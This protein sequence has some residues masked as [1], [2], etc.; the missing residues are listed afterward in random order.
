MKINADA[1]GLDGARLEHITEHLTARYIE[2]QKIAG[3]QVAV[4]RHGELGY[5][6]SFGSMDLERAKPVQDDTIWRIYSMTKPVTSVALMTLYERGLFQLDDPVG[7]FLPELAD[8]QVAEVEGGAIARTRPPARPIQVRD[9][10]MHTAGLSY[11]GLLGLEAA[12]AVDKL[13]ADAGIAATSLNGPGKGSLAELIEALGTVPLKFDPGTRWHYSYATDVCSRLVEVLSGQRFSDYL[14]TTMFEPLG[15][16]DTGFVVADEDVDRFAANY[17]RRRDK[18]LKLLDDPERSG[19]R[20]DGR[21]ESGGGGLVSTTADYVRFCQMLLNGG[22]LDGARVLGRK[23]I[24]LMTANH[25]PGGGDL[26][27]LAVGSFSETKYDGVGFG[28]G[29]AV[30]QGPVAQRTVGSTGE[31]FWGGAASTIFWIDPAEDLAVVF[32]TQ[33]V[34]SATFDFRGQLKT[35][36][37]PAIVD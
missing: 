23:T 20:R 34:P 2:P 14:R 3:C 8:M 17:G 24:E 18:T 32:M 37:Y 36:V 11:G 6:R 19:Y 4:V 16:V 12:D 30:G 22:E 26:A 13:Y 7:R 9:V 25:L 10:L 5:F 27:G 35:L 29:F 15:M 21:L 33:L 28:L 31:Y 1:A